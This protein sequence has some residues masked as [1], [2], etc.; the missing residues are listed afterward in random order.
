MTSIY[1]KLGNIFL[2]IKYDSVPQCV[3]SYKVCVFRE[4]HFQEIIMSFQFF[5][6]AYVSDCWFQVIGKHKLLWQQH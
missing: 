2:I 5:D 3:I 6:N 4:V 1:R